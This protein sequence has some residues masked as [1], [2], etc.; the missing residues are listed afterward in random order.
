VMS[1]YDD[2][3]FAAAEDG[4]GSTTSEG[5]AANRETRRSE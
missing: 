3:N 1:T 4:Q 2:A 5:W